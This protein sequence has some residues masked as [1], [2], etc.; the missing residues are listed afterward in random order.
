MKKWIISSIVGLSFILFFLHT[1]EAEINDSIFVNCKYNGK[2][3]KSYEK[4]RINIVFNDSVYCLRKNDQTFVFPN[5]ISG[6]IEMIVFYRRKSYI[7]PLYPYN[8][9]NASTGL[10]IIIAKFD[11]K[12]RK[13]FD[14]DYIITLIS[15]GVGASEKGFW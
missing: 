12:K 2:T 6:H 3:I 8:R 13:E 10:E 5:T 14:C 15:S 9:I 7:F 11:R 4:L 1:V